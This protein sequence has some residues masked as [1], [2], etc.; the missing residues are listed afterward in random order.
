MTPGEK[1]NATRKTRM[2]FRNEV[3]PMNPTLAKAHPERGL[4]ARWLTGL[5]LAL[6]WFVVAALSLWAMAALYIDVRL[7][8]LRIPL[9]L[10]YAVVLVVI[11]VRYK[12]H[13]RSA[14]LCVGCF[15]LVLAWW[16]NL[17]PTNIGDWQPD[18]DRP[19]WVDIDGD[20]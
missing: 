20:R 4:A 15:C 9:T 6:V 13:L 1:G 17:K 3:S 14:L 18:V 19:A 10:L 2:A 5:G 11:L 8:A 7:S 12:L 16:L